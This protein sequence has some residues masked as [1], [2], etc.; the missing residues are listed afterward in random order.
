VS[1]SLFFCLK[2][3][4]NLIISIQY[5]SFFPLMYI[6]L[7]HFIHLT[8]SLTIINKCVLVNKIHCEY[9]WWSFVYIWKRKN[10][11]AQESSRWHVIVMMSDRC[12]AICK[13]KIEINWTVTLRMIMMVIIGISTLSFS[14]GKVRIRQRTN[15][16]SETHT[17]K[18]N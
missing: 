3:F 13:T 18:L 17:S 9:L 11:M 12:V 16:D 14:L 8:T 6:Y 10:R 7:L 15:S 2:L 4:V 5:L 1:S